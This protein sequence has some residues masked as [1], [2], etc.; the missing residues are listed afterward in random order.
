M[1]IGTI[2]ITPAKMIMMRTSIQ[3]YGNNASKS[4]EK[5][6]RLI[7][8]QEPAT[9]IKRVT[10]SWCSRVWQALIL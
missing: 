5:L 4:T 9:L 8:Q 2:V 3:K 1:R 6:L 7:I 10:P